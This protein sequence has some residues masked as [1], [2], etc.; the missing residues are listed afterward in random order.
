MCYL[1]GKSS[2]LDQLKKGHNFLKHLFYLPLSKTLK[3]CGLEFYY[4]V[5][6]YENFSFNKGSNV[7]VGEEKFT[8]IILVLRETFL[9]PY[10]SK[11][12]S[13]KENM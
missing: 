8:Y 4:D 2:L 12:E 11:G 1:L 10:I 13:L 7:F 9:C 5:S 6:I 3:T